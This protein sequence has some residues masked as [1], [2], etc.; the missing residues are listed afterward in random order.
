LLSQLS[1]SRVKDWPNPPLEPT[2]DSM[3][4]NFSI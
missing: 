4:N 2:R 3:V 1:E